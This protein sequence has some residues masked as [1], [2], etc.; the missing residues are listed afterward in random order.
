[1]NISLKDSGKS[2][3]DLWAFASLMSVEYGVQTNNMVCNGNYNNNPDNQCNEDV[4]KESCEINFPRS[5]IFKTGRK[6]CTETGDKPY[7]ALKA[8]NHPNPAGNGNLTMNFFKEDF[9]MNGRE[10][11]TIMGAHTFGRLHN[12]ISLYKYMWTTRATALFN[13]QYYK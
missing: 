7:K 13:N 5:F 12:S 2:R 10:V 3:A 9:D 1:M 4:G 6:D 11:V 8:E